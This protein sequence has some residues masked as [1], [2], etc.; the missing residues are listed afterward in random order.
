MLGSIQS[1]IHALP[2]THLTALEGGYS[3]Y[4]PFIAEETEA[5]REV[6]GFAPDHS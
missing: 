3:D 4:P 6:E 2:H 1:P 5:Q